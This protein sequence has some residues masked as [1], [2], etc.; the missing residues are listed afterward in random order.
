MYIGIGTAR[1]SVDRSFGMTLQGRAFGEKGSK[2][3]WDRQW[4]REF[5]EFCKTTWNVERIHILTAGCV[6]ID[7]NEKA[8]YVRNMDI[9]D[10]KNGGLR[11]ATAK[12]KFVEID[13][14]F[15]SPH[16]YHKFLNKMNASTK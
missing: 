12:R 4:R 11:I 16:A 7:T 8:Y 9:S 14:V 1:K 15:K 5:R 6:F 2:K 3:K 13:R 10:S